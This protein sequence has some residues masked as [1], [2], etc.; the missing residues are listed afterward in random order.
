[1]GA[2]AQIRK[3]RRLPEN[4]FIS[5]L[6]A[7]GFGGGGAVVVPGSSTIDELP[8]SAPPAGVAFACDSLIAAVKGGTETSPNCWVV[9]VGGPGNGKSFQ[10][11][12]VIDQLKLSSLSDADG[13]ALR[14]QWNN[15]DSSKV[16][17]V[18]D[19]T[20]RA[21]NS[22]GED[23]GSLA[24]ELHTLHYS[25][26]HDAT[27]ALISVNRGILIEEQAQVAGK[28]GWLTEHQLI[29]WLVRQDI[30]LP[31]EWSRSPESAY[32]RRIVLPENERRQQIEIYAVYLDQLSLMERQPELT[33][34]SIDDIP[35]YRTMRPNH[36]D[37]DTTPVA[38]LVRKVTIAE[39]FE[40]QGCAD[41]PCQDLCPI[42]ANVRN[43][44]QESVRQGLFEFLRAAEVVSG[45][46][47][48]YRDLWSVLATVVA[49]S[50]ETEL[51]GLHKCAWIQQQAE[52]LSDSEK[53]TEAAFNLSRQRYFD[54]LFHEVN[55]FYSREQEVST[56][57]VSGAIERIRSIDPVID[58][59]RVWTEPVLESVQAISYDQLP[60]NFA[61]AQ[62]GEFEGLVEEIDKVVEQ[63]IV[64]Q[65]ISDESNVDDLERRAILRWRGQT[66]FRQFGVRKGVAAHDEV[67][68][69]WLILRSNVGDTFAPI[70]SDSV[71]DAALRFLLLPPA[72][73]DEERYCLLPLFESRVIPVTGP[74]E[75]PV[76]CHG[77][78]RHD[79]R[80]N[81]KAVG[82]SLEIGLFRNFDEKI[83]V[84]ELDFNVCR[85][86]LVCLV[87]GGA[88]TDC[89]YGF[90]E[91]GNSV[92][93]RLERI[94]A[95]FLAHL[96]EQNSDLVF[97][98]QSGLSTLRAESTG[99]G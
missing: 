76:W 9:L 88:R 51:N 48:T 11:Q 93:P 92:S 13:L 38:D 2:D 17:I 39:N 70:P 28:D 89:R 33:V 68:K 83:A 52:D 62:I 81:I 26:Q 32:F 44:R 12:R 27:H 65:L 86:S 73:F 66:L 67:V 10:V 64:G 74:Q 34:D 36:P 75:L 87:F 7:R 29:S 95:S 61:A 79:V 59:A 63:E 55:P 97:I 8:S 21:E 72:S 54:A 3:G 98:A 40:D 22:T 41:C 71:L 57:D 43:L 14:S 16:L 49:G 69:A 96:G 77:I 37:R 53:R 91:L 25:A 23:V 31:S 30:E 78:E 58:A 46:L 50:S 99:N 80:W 20:I 42:L 47:F 4:A 84:F 60:L 56:R 85:E 45:H 19:A 6:I 15:L 24:R 1:M 90:T 5:K 94:R 18:N 82:D 35:K